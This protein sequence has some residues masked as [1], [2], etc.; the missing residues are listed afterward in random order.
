MIELEELRIGNYLLYDGKVVHVTLLTLDIDDEYEDTICFCELG[1]TTNEKGGWN[2]ELADKLR[3]I[4]ISRE[5]L[6]RLGLS[7]S[8][9]FNCYSVDW[10]LMFCEDGDKYYLCE[11]EV[12]ELRK[13]GKPFYHVHQLQNLYFALTG[14]ELKIK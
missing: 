11:Q 9:T 6:E 8:K 13:I 4:A 1:K 2:R 5:W 3:R 7:Y 14:E 12:G 10:E